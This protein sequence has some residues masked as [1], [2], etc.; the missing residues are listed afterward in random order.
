[1]NECFFPIS[2]CSALQIMLILASPPMLC[3]LQQSVQRSRCSLQRVFSSFAESFS[4]CCSSQKIAVL[5]VVIFPP[6]DLSRIAQKMNVSTTHS[7]QK[8]CQWHFFCSSLSLSLSLNSVHFLVHEMYN[9][10]IG[11]PFLQ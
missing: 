10:V 6:A 4:C 11:T 1:M 3:I 5:V 9:I 2:Y 8:K 7:Q